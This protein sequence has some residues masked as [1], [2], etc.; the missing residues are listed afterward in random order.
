MRSTS[1]SLWKA[2][3]SR[4]RIFSMSKSS[5]ILGVDEEEAVAFTDIPVGLKILG[6]S[7]VVVRIRING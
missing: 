5:G 3:A 6:N 2:E 7:L 1:T 4:F